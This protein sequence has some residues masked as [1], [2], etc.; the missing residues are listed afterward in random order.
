VS[1]LDTTKLTLSDMA[2]TAMSPRRAGQGSPRRAYKLRSVSRKHVDHAQPADGA[3]RTRDSGLGL[4]GARAE[5]EIS[6]R[7]RSNARRGLF[8][9]VLLALQFGIQPIFVRKFIDRSRVDISSTVLVQEAVK[10]IISVLLF[11]VDSSICHRSVWR[12]FTLKESL[13]FAFFPA[14]L[15][16]AQ[17]LLIQSGSDPPWPQS[18]HRVDNR[19]FVSL[20]G[21]GTQKHTL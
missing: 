17:N 21:N 7:A 2:A 8:F 11:L 18:T 1:I 10:L 12:S 4:A 16:S 15:Y 19:D 6:Q 3:Q 13:E 20:Q 9:G 14:I 5:K